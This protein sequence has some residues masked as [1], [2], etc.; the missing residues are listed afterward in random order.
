L[1][2]LKG[3]SNYSVQ[4]CFQLDHPVG[5]I[6][7]TYGGANNQRHFGDILPAKGKEV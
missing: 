4:E 1:K 7:M 5:S 6:N 2:E 3:P